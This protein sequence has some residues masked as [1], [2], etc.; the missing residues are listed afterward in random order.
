[1]AAHKVNSKVNCVI[2]GISTFYE[3]CYFSCDLRGRGP[4]QNVVFSGGL[5]MKRQRA[6]VTQRGPGGAPCLWLLLH[7]VGKRP[8]SH[9]SLSG[10]RTL[11]TCVMVPA[12]QRCRDTDRFLP[13][14]DLCHLH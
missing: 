11:R 13:N 3:E 10:V 4:N 2:R 7:C 9:K 12:A 14:F 5:W 8:S 1:M 6:M